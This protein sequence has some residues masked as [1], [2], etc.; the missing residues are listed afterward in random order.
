MKVNLKLIALLL[1]IPFLSG[2]LTTTAFM[3]TMQQ[4]SNLSIS[5]TQEKLGKPYKISD[6]PTQDQRKITLYVYAPFLSKK[7]IAYFV[8]GKGKSTRWHS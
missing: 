2:C 8:D 3:R 5:K 1:L 7:L 4:G 6:I